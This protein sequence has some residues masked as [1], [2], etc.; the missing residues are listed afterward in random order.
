MNASIEGW[1]TGAGHA[2]P[3]EFLVVSDRKVG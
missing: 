2:V 1:G 3:G